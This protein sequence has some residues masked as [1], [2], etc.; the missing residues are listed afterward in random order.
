MEETFYAERLARHGITALSPDADDRTLVDRVVFDE[1]TQ[2]RLLDSSRR[3]YVEVIERLAGRGADA[4]VL[5]CTEIG[6]LVGPADSPLPL[7]DSAE[8]HASALAEV[9]LAVPATA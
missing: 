8:A 4:V 5:A 7:I 9:A 2:G 3:S 1:L 6:L